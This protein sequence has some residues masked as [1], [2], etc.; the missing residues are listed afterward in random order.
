MQDLEGLDAGAGRNNPN[1][2]T[3]PLRVFYT[4][5][6]NYKKVATV[7]RGDLLFIKKGQTK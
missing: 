6:Q 5:L 1:L 4:F 7:K 2:N 3:L